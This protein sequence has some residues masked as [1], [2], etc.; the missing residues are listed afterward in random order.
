V[1]IVSVYRRS[2]SFPFL[3]SLG[4]QVNGLIEWLTVEERH[5]CH[6]L[7][8]QLSEHARAAA[9]AAAANAQLA[10]ASKDQKRRTRP[11]T[12]TSAPPTAPTPA[13]S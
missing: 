4:E 13:T 6:Q 11:T 1:S 12:N 2:C 8:L 10:A 7:S 3:H 9:A 5:Y